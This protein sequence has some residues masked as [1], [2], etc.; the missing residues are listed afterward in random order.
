MLHSLRAHECVCVPGLNINILLPVRPGSSRLP[1]RLPLINLA[2]HAVF[3]AAT[4]MLL[5]PLFGGLGAECHE[6]AGRRKRRA[7]PEP[8]NAP[9][10]L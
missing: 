2:V 9:G 8:N 7:M 3:A 1:L 6:T 10:G 5:Y 4:S